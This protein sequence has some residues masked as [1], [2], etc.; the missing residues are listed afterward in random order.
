M[1]VEID[2]V[3]EERRLRGGEEVRGH[4][5]DQAFPSCLGKGRV[6]RVGEEESAPEPGQHRIGAVPADI[7]SAWEAN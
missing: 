6:G 4:K 3:G 1:F 7:V 2:D 5:R